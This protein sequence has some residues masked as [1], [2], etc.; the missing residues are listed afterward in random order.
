M[1]GPELT[2]LLGMGRESGKTG[3]IPMVTLDTELSLWCYSVPFF[4]R[5]N[6]W[7]DLI[8]WEVHLTEPSHF[9]GGEGFPGG[10]DSKESACNVGDLDSIPGLGRSPGKGNG[11]P[12]QYSG[13]EN[14]MD[15]GAWQAAVHGVAKSW[16]RLSDFHF[17]S[18]RWRDE[19]W[20][21]LYH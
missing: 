7:L 6:N 8:I 18:C 14:S 4:E 19:E 21:Q 13:L 2:V 17:K 15:R 12:L 9:F 10:S 1:M 20:N 5:E 16:T 11:Y 3:R